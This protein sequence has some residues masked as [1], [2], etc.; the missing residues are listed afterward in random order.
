MSVESFDPT[1]QAVSVTPAALAHFRRQ[2]TNQPGKSVRVSIKK[3]GCTGFMY[4]ID[5]VEQGAESDV[6]YQL[7]DQVELLVD[8]NSLAVL[9]GTQ[10]DIVQEGINRQIRFIN[11]NV[12]DQC[13]CGESFSVS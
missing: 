10:I 3:S 8:Q 13:G 2:L 9:S 5:M 7:D 1:S 11:P 12:K 6:H 4:V